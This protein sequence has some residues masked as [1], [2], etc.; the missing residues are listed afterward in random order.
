MRSIPTTPLAQAFWLVCIAACFLML[1]V[2][3]YVGLGVMCA[4]LI[5]WTAGRLAGLR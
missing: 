5:L 1:F 4:A 3:P 2:S